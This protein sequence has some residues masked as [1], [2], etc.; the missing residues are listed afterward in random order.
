MASRFPEFY[1]APWPTIGTYDRM[2]REILNAGLLLSNIN[3]ADFSLVLKPDKSPVASVQLPT[4]IN[5]QY[6]KL[7]VQ[8]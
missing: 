5:N 6:L 4:N 8:P 2:A 1:K 7:S 3:S